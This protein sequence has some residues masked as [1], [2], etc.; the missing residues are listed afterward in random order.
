MQEIKAFPKNNKIIKTST[1]WFIFIISLLCVLLII[2]TV[3]LFTDFF[4]QKN[5]S[6]GN[7]QIG[8]VVNVNV[9]SQGAFST[10]ITYDGTNIPGAKINQVVKISLPLNDVKTVVRG[11][12]YVCDE[13]GNMID[14][15]LVVANESWILFNGY[16]FYNSV[17]EPGVIT[18]FCQSLYL[19]TQEKFFKM[20]QYYEI[21]IIFETLEYENSDYNYLSIW[22]DVPENW[23]L[24]A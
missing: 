16:Y 22:K 15:N 18:N 14:I 9:K 19:P 20:D 23:L 13:E 1:K 3:L 12:A 7:I 6:V 5:F 17:L 8:E 21:I 2:E 11:R 10:S 24:N 4:K